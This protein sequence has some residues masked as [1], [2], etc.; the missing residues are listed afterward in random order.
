MEKEFFKAEVTMTVY[1]CYYSNC[2]KEFP[3]KYNL[4]RHIETVHLKC[5]Q[6]QCNFC[7]KF[8]ANLQNLREHLNLHTG[9]T[10]YVCSVCKE[11][12]RYASQLSLHKRSHLIEGIPREQIKRARP[13]HQVKRVAGIYAPPSTVDSE[14]QRK[15]AQVQLPEIKDEK[16]QCYLPLAKEIRS[17]N[18]SVYY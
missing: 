2:C 18:S 9:N 6:Y 15:T 11:S 1:C 12:Y 5:K 7:L 8:F 17:V 16:S 3:T 14:L 13:R 4:K 10:P